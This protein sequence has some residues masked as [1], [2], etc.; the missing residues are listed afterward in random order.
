MEGGF[1]SELF[2]AQAHVWNHIFHFI[3]SMTLKCAIQL[4][5]PDAIHNHQKP[6][7]IN[8]LINALQIHPK[9]AEYV[10]RLMRILVH[11]G[12]FAQQKLSQNDKEHGYILTNA[13]KLLLKDN[14]LSVRPFVQAVLDPV[15]T[16]PWQHVTTWFQNDDPTPFVTAHGMAFW[17]ILSTSK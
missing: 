9:K 13:S 7:T 15:L 5:I 6:M 4:G 12:F 16:T 3:N 11:S 14:P 1:D 8:E 2:Q 17:S 10:Y